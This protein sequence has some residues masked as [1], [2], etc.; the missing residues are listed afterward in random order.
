MK[1]FQEICE[2]CNKGKVVWPFPTILKDKSVWACPECYHKEHPGCM[3]VFQAKEVGPDAHLELEGVG[4]AKPAKQGQEIVFK[5]DGHVFKTVMELA[6]EYYAGT[7]PYDKAHRLLTTLGEGQEEWVRKAILNLCKGK[8]EDS[9]LYGLGHRQ[10][11][12]YFHQ[13][14]KALS[15]QKVNG[16]TSYGLCLDSYLPA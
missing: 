5:C 15:L 6:R 4:I 1:R 14:I 12:P 16:K 8:R 10:T 3:P 2:V 13:D 7:I 9:Q 11:G